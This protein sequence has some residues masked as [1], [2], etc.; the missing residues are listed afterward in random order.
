MGLSLKI[1]FINSCYLSPGPTVLSNDENFID[2]GG[3][4]VFTKFHKNQ[5]HKKV[6]FLDD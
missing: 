3:F 6:M 1:Y 5:N 2:F 4:E